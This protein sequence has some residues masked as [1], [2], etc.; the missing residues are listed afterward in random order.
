VIGAVAGCV[1]GRIAGAAVF[2]DDDAV[3]PI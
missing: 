1:D 3:V 2:V